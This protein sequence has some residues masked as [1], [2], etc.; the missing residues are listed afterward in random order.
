MLLVQPGSYSIGHTTAGEAN[1]PMIGDNNVECYYKVC[2]LQ[3]NV[4]PLQSK[5]VSPLCADPQ[6]IA[7]SGMLPVGLLVRLEK[8]ATR[9]SL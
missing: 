2:A 5:K 1:D 6:E 7:I 9:P 4:S 8:V 3:L